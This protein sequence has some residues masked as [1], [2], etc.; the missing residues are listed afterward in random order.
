MSDKLNNNAFSVTLEFLNGLFTLNNALIIDAYFIEDIFSPFVT[1]AITFSDTAGIFEKGPITGNEMIT[2]QYTGTS[3]GDVLI[4]RTFIVYKISEITALDNTDPNNTTVELLFIDPIFMSLGIQQFSRSWKEEYGHDIIKHIV[5]KIGEI[6]EKFLNLEN[7]AWE[8]C[9]EKF[10]FYMPWWN[11]IDSIKWLMKRMSSKKTELSGYLFYSNGYQSEKPEREG[12]STINLTTIDTLLS[13]TDRMKISVDD[14]AQ[15]IITPING[16]DSA[17]D[18]TTDETSDIIT[19]KKDEN[20]VLSWSISS[21]DKNSIKGIAGGHYYG[22]NNK[23]KRLI[24]KEY[25]YDENM[26]KHTVLGLSSLFSD[27]SLADAGRVFTGEEDEALI[28]NIMYDDWVSRY[29]MQHYVSIVVP[30]H[31]ARYVGGLIELQFPTR[32]TSEYPVNKAL[33]GGYLV[34]TIT[35]YFSPQDFIRYRQKMV[36]IKNG[37]D[38]EIN[39]LDQAEKK[40]LFVDL[41]NTLGK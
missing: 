18:K 17:K 2:F 20:N 14:D 6:D 8:E 35:H 13:K 21:I 30:G 41:S 40:N 10:D 34:K 33:S 36:L 32:Y 23:E 22:F 4:K 39:G 3:E 7:D 31:H 25:T 16:T 19:S 12:L 15:Y 26:K 1:G 37:Y 38:S 5:T 9:R 29:I 11:C 24:D 27:I 28:Q